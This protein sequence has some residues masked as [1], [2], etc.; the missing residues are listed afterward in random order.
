[1]AKNRVDFVLFD[2]HLCNENRGLLHFHIWKNLPL[3]RPQ[4]GLFLWSH[5][6]H[7]HHSHPLLSNSACRVLSHIAL[8]SAG[9]HHWRFNSNMFSTLNSLGCPV[10]PFL[11]NH[12]SRCVCACV[13]VVY[14]MVW[15][16]VKA[17]MCLSL[18]YKKAEMRIKEG[19]TMTLGSPIFFFTI[20]W[21][22]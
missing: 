14:W 1:M 10:V 16:R 19:V 8:C 5:F 12:P 18:D 6:L 3:V 21:M 15:K 13:C 17:I 2:F 20:A 11:L 22:K 7:P 4:A 9:H